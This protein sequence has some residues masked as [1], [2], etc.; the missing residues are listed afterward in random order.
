MTT[1]TPTTQ[2]SAPTCPRCDTR[3]V[4]LEGQKVYGFDPDLGCLWCA[5]TPGETIDP[6]DAL[7]RL[8]SNRFRQVANGY[9]RT[10]ALAYGDIARAAAD[11]NEQVAATVAAWERRQGIPIGDWQAIG[12][13]ESKPRS[14]ERCPR[15]G[16]HFLD[17]DDGFA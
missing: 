12:A 16:S 6:E 4:D 3:Y 2:P 10:V 9:P 15:C 8:H 7:R 14:E 17:P 5:W 11:T 13:T 1:P